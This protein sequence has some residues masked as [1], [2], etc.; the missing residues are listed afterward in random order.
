M[1][2]CVV[3]KREELARWMDGANASGILSRP[4]TLSD[5]EVEQGASLTDQKAYQQTTNLWSSK[6]VG[7][8]WPKPLISPLV[9][10]KLF[11]C[12][13]KNVMSFSP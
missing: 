3:S 12:I 7:T 4:L 2:F 10:K 11:P 6:H 9:G 1:L 13:K 5:R 8:D